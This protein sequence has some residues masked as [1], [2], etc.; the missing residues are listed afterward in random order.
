MLADADMDEAQNAAAK[1]LIEGPRK[2]VFGPFVPL[3]R[4]PELLDRVAKVGEYLRFGSG[5]DGRVR[6]LVICAVSRH[7]SNQFEWLMHSPLAL[8]AGISEQTI[9]ALRVGQRPDNLRKDE[10]LA[11]DFTC[12]LL[13]THGVSGST[14]SQSEATFGQ[15]GIVELSTLIGYFVMVSWL[16]NVAKTPAQQSGHAKPLDAFPQ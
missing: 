14:Y 11:L 1:A 3:L 7:V 4:T 16:M 8:A 13:T 5:L 6:E 2:G 10:Q 15:K 12:E 9:E